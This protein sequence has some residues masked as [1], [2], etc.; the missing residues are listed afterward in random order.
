M[1]ELIVEVTLFSTRMTYLIWM[2]KLHR[3]KVQFKDYFVL[4]SVINGFSEEETAKSAPKLALG[5]A[6]P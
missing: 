6:K 4:R 1:R 5:M 3:I 2:F